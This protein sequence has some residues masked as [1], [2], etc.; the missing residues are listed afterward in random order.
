MRQ[1]FTEHTL[2]AYP[3]SFDRLVCPFLETREHHCIIELPVRTSSPPG[4]WP[5]RVAGIYFVVNTCCM[6]LA[7]ANLVAARTDA[8]RWLQV[9]HGWNPRT[10]GTA[11]GWQW[12]T[13]L[14]LGVAGVLLI[15]LTSVAIWHGR[16]FLGL[17]ATGVTCVLAVVLWW[18]TNV[19]VS[20]CNGCDGGF[21]DPISSELNRAGGLFALVALVG[22]V[23]WRLSAAQR[24]V[25]Y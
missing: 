24:Q 6:A 22:G 25:N 5:W 4:T 1:Q 3:D 9:R 13:Y 23:A 15:L 19:S 12:E 11:G 2:L 7:T 18:D 14:L 16:D 10:Y 17:A 21:P 8:A 20:I